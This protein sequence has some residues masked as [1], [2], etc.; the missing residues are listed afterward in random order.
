MSVQEHKSTRRVRRGAGV[1]MS[2]GASMKASD[3]DVARMAAAVAKVR[4]ERR[5]VMVA[6]AAYFR[7]GRRGFRAWS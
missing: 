4:K 5:E 7:A 6:T 1:A 2:N 3:A